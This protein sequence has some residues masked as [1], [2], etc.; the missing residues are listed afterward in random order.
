RAGGTI[1]RI[2]TAALVLSALAF[3]YGPSSARDVRLHIKMSPQALQ[4]ACT[5]AGGHFSQGEAIYGCG[6]DC[7]GNAGTDCTV[8]CRPGKLCI[9]QTMGGRRAH[10]VA[11][12]LKARGRYPR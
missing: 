10:T 3:A 8:T 7:H 6:T 9:A 5:D 2:L 11:Q 1:L 12:A 4:Q